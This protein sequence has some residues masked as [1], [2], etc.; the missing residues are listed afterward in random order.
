[1]CPPFLSPKREGLF[2]EGAPQADGPRTEQFS[3][4][5]IAYPSQEHPERELIN[6]RKYRMVSCIFWG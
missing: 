4:K 5:K 3:S 6:R 1:M 2:R